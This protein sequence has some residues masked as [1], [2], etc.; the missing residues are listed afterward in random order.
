[1]A[2]EQFCNGRVVAVVHAKRHSRRLP[3]KNLRILGDKPMFCHAL[4][5][6]MSVG[7]FDIVVI[8]SEDDEILRIGEERGATPMKRPGPFAN[9]TTSGDYLAW[10]QCN[11]F[12]RASCVVQIVPTSPFINPESVSGAIKKFQSSDDIKSVV[13]CREQS[14]YTWTDGRPDYR[15]HGYLP[16][17]DQ[18]DI[19]L[20]ETT[21]LYLMDPAMV[22]EQMGRVASGHCVPY[23]LSPVESIDINN[24]ADWE[25]AQ[26][27]WRGLHA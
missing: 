9:D 12:W 19:T 21:G 7:V 14:L 6:A 26:L 27:V 1:M 25:L 24:E 23:L 18:L 17:S 2:D 13:G 20:H 22:M 5:T 3:G 10:R 11:K 4:D 16:N 15:R 8:D